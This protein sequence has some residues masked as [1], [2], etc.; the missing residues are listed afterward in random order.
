[1]KP[2]SPK[3]NVMTFFSIYIF[4]APTMYLEEGYDNNTNNNKFLS[5][6]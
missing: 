6:Y 3:N 4:L 5:N 1:M 2:Y